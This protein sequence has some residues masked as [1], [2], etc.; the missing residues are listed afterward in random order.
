[1]RSWNKS[2]RLRRE[3]VAFCDIEQRDVLLNRRISGVVHARPP[4]I[5]CHMGYED[6]ILRA[7][8]IPPYGIV[9]NGEPRAGI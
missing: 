3:A 6:E 5:P 4:V 1:V 9:T 8:F 2:G 7:V